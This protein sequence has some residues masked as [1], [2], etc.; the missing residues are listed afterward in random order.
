MTIKKCLLAIWI[1][2]AI[3]AVV[4]AQQFL[5]IEK[6]SYWY[7]LKGAW[8]ESKPQTSEIDF[9]NYIANGEHADNNYFGLKLSAGLGKRFL[10]D[11]RADRF[12]NTSIN[13]MGDVQYFLKP[14]FGFSVGGYMNN[15]V[16]DN[17]YKDFFVE[18]SSGYT[19]Y[20]PYQ[21]YPEQITRY[22]HWGLNGGLF[23]GYN[24]NRINL[25]A[26]LNA[27]IGRNVQFTILVGQKK[28]GSNIRRELE[29]TTNQDLFLFV[30]P[31]I[32][33][34]FDIFEFEKSTF[35]FEVTSNMMISRKTLSYDV[36]E[37]VWTNES[38]TT[39]SV[40]TPLRRI[41]YL[42]VDFSIFWKF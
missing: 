2:A 40:E 7:G 21:F 19:L 14:N 33:L 38:S 5:R 13:L 24:L 39:Q 35:G 8:T 32:T 42:N 9:L 16:I 34:G 31:E 4:S 22:Y 41:T 26:S 17:S 27:G 20:T 3:P 30:V 23:F 18:Q 37:R 6:I 28:L 29:F 25:K 12:Q 1:I 15:Q 36:T 10:V 11:F